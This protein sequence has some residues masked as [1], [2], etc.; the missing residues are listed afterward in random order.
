MDTVLTKVPGIAGFIKR[1]TLRDLDAS[2]ATLRSDQKYCAARK[3][4]LVALVVDRTYDGTNPLPDRLAKYALK[5]LA[6]ETSGAGYATVR[7]HPEYVDAYLA[8]V[9]RMDCVI[10]T[11]E[12]SL[13]LGADQLDA[14]GYTPAKYVDSYLK[15][16]DSVSHDVWWIFNYIPR[17]QSAINSVL[18]DGGRRKIPGGP[19]CWP[20]DLSLTE[21]VYPFYVH[22]NM[23][24]GISVP[25]YSQPGW[26]IKQ[27]Y[28]YARDILKVRHVCWVYSAGLFDQAIPIINAY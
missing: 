9:K 15:I 14:W 27:V 4:E 22:E 26:T 19:D 5:T 16:I 1:Y 10:A 21:R 3:K 23:F 2:L 12:T 7:W 8:L 24:I 18:T 11:Q 13:G 25:S 28:E 6:T 20:A 17:D